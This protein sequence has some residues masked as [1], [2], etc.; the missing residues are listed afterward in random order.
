M[1]LAELVFDDRGRRLAGTIAVP[2]EKA[3]GGL[4][5]V[6]GSG[7]G[8]RDWWDWPERFAAVGVATLAY[9]KPGVGESEGDWMLQTLEDRAIEAIAAADALAE[10]AGI[11]TDRV[12]LAPWPEGEPLHRLGRDLEVL[13]RSVPADAPQAA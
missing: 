10:G 9:D 7:P 4:V 1:R 12:G 6:Q 2:D 5:F 13:T 8:D 3:S 11:G